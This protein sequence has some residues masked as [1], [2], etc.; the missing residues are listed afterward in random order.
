MPWSRFGVSD[1]SRVFHALNHCYQCSASF[2]SLQME[3][4]TRVPGIV[5]HIEVD[6]HQTGSLV[7]STWYGF[8]ALNLKT[9]PLAPQLIAGKE[10]TWGYAEG[11]GKSIQNSFCSHLAR[12]RPGMTVITVK[13]PHT[14][15]SDT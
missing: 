14:L 2:F 1:S 12:G 4:F 8:Y 9:H 15:C 13:M 11:T 10:G 6:I 5:L 3:T 7:F